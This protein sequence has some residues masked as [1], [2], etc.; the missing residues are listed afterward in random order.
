MVVP[1]SQSL[2]QAGPPSTPSG[3]W[4]GSLALSSCD[5]TLHLFLLSCLPLTLPWRQPFAFIHPKQW[6]LFFQWVTCK[7]PLCC[8]LDWILPQGPS[9][10]PS[11]HHP[12]PHSSHPP[13]TQPSGAL[14]QEPALI[15]EVEMNK[16]KDPRYPQLHVSHFVMGCALAPQNNVEEVSLISELLWTGWIDLEEEVAWLTQDSATRGEG[17]DCSYRLAASCEAPSVFQ[18]LSLPLP[19]GQQRQKWPTAWA[20]SAR[21]KEQA[22]PLL[23]QV[24]KPLLPP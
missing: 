1:T 18:S 3:G 14:V 4:C 23:S 21:L 10:A 6:V 17:G 11:P 24:C 5:A 12:F 2:L 20:S 7:V 13:D 22:S 8:P 16:V 9:L 15:I 19:T